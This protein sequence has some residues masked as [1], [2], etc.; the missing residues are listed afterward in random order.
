MKHLLLIFLLSSLAASAQQIA[1]KLPT[2]YIR[3]HVEQEQHNRIL[4]YK[5]RG[6]EALFGYADPMGHIVI[7]AQFPYASPFR[8]GYAIVAEGSAP[9]HKKGV[10]D[11]L[12]RFITPMRWITVGSLNSD[13]LLVC[14]EEGEVRKF[15]YLNPSGEVVIDCEADF[16]KDFSEGVAVFGVGDYHRQRISPNSPLLKSE[17]F[18]PRNLTWLFEGSYGLIDTAGRIVA[19]AQYQEI[20]PMKEGRAAAAKSGKYYP[21]WGFLAADGTEVI[22]FDYFMVEEFSDGRAVV[23]KIINGEPKYGYIDRKGNVVV[24]LT[25]DH[26]SPYRNKSM[27]VGKSG[28]PNSTFMLLDENGKA[29]LTKPVYDLNDSNRYGYASCAIRSASGQLLY[30]VVDP[31]GKIIIPFEY[32]HIYLYNEWDKQKYCYVERGIAYKDEE[33]YSFTLSE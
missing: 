28:Q 23:A 29:L 16:A 18:D 5:G 21:K 9:Y 10:I 4:I 2:G 22:P 3:E 25:W 8:D 33:S 24:P 27:W 26:A 6:E 14:E 11:T 12:G 31:H 1:F 17:Q 32:D 15:H 13:R 19:Q 7:E 30:G 20:R